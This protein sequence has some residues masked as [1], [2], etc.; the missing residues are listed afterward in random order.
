[1]NRNTLKIT[2]SAARVNAG[3]SQ[4]E[5]ADKL[6]LKVTTLATWEKDS[7]KL[8]YIEANR[9]AKLYGI[10]PDLLFFG[11]RNEFIRYLRGGNTNEPINQSTS[12]E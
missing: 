9:L 12:Q 4:Q 1:M 5:A 3:Y 11:N 7:T 6:G 2:L 10:Q 8:S